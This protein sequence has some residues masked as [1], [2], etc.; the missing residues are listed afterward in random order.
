MKNIKKSFSYPIIFMILVTAFFTLVLSLLNYTTKDVIAQNAQIDECKTLLYVF[1]ID[2][3]NDNDKKIEKLYRE[4]LKPIKVNDLTI[5]EAEKDGK[6]LGYAFPVEGN[7]LWGTIKGYAAV[8]ENINTLLG[9]DFVSHSE[10]PGLGGRIDEMWFKN[11]FRNIDLDRDNK[12]YL[13]Y[14]P[15]ADGNVDAI[16]GATLTSKSVKNLLNQ[17][18]EEFKDLMKGEDLNGK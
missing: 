14:R 11:Q 9:V 6:E 2:Y 8:D 18:I 13:E 16:T 15:A 17:D 10:T 12:N 5:Y 7:G 3:P 4:H 1:D